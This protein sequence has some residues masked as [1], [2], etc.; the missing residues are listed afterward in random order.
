MGFNMNWCPVWSVHDS[1]LRENWH[2][3]NIFLKASWS[4]LEILLLAKYA[5]YT[6]SL[7]KKD[8]GWSWSEI[9]LANHLFIYLCIYVYADTMGASDVYCFYKWIWLDQKVLYRYIT[10]KDAWSL[11]NTSSV[12]VSYIIRLLTALPVII[13]NRLIL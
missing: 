9:L 1:Y 2:S 7:G 10:C 12:E 3:G 13:P 11:I 4:C 5:K 6:C 8:G